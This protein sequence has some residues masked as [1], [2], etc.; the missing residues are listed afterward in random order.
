[1]ESKIPKEAFPMI[2][3]VEN[4]ALFFDGENLFLSYEIAP[5]AGGGIAILIFYDVIYFEKNPIN[6][7]GIMTSRYPVSPWNFTEV[8]GSD[9][10]AKWRALKPRFW[11]ISF[12][13]RTVEVVFSKVQ[14][15]HEIR[16][17]VSPSSAL[18]GFLSS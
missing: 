16:D 13:D 10:T 18:K 5:A 17:V 8:T 12:N 9:R 11:T 6:V 4:P 7:D 15:V 2:G 3:T 1:M 14:K